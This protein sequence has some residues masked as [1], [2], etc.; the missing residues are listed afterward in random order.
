MKTYVA[1][2]VFASLLGLA[3]L[4]DA[5]QL[6][7]GPLPTHPRETNVTTYGA[8]VSGTSGPRRSP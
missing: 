8:R 6:L 1:G 3:G 5:A 2:T 7:S 4:T